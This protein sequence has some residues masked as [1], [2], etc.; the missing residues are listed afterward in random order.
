MLLTGL[1][2]GLEITRVHNVGLRG[3]ER[4]LLV[5]GVHEGASAVG[6]GAELAGVGSVGSWGG[7]ARRRVEQ[8]RGENEWGPFICCL[9]L[10]LLL[11]LLASEVR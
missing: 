4:Q 3:V 8:R 2:C 1:L 11:L 10:L 9:L 5:P 6:M 7:V